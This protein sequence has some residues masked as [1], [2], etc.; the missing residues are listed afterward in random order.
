MKLLSVSRYSDSHDYK[1]T[2][3]VEFESEHKGPL[4]ASATCNYAETP[5][6]FMSVFIEVSACPLQYSQHSSAKMSLHNSR[7]MA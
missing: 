3:C 4:R 7:N 2:Q 1:Y 5:S 6:M